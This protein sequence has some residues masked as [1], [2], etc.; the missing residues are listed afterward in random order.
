MS[1]STSEETL[2][3]TVEWSALKSVK[4]VNLEKIVKLVNLVIVVK[5]VLLEKICII[6]NFKFLIHYWYW[7][8]NIRCAAMDIRCL[9][10]WLASY[11]SWLP[12]LLHSPPPFPPPLLPSPL[13]IPPIPLPLLVGN[14]GGGGGLEVITY[15]EGVGYNWLYTGGGWD[16]QRLL[17]GAPL[18]SLWGGA[19]HRGQVGFTPLGPGVKPTPPWLPV[20]HRGKTQIP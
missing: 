13:P 15:Q 8:N 11:V 2:D 9:A 5:T 12:A 17:R 10:A 19:L 14:I 7:Y 20:P 16:D 6:V 18:F 1:F 3:C 4:P